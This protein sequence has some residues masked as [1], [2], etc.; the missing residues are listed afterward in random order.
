MK[1]NNPF[2]YRLSQFIS[3]LLGIRVFV[4]FL[5]VLALYVSTFFLFNQEESLRRFVFDYK[6]HGIILCSVLSIAAGG[7]INQFYDLE[8]D[9]IQRPF[10]SRIQ[11]FLKTKYFLYSYLILN[12][13]S[14][15][16]AW[17]L[18]PR[19]FAFFFIYQFIMW[20]YSHKLSKIVFVNNLTFVVLT[21]YPFFGMLVYY[22]H[23]SWPLFWMAAFL[24]VILLIIDSLKDILTIRPDK[25]FGYHTIA[26]DYSLRFSA[27]YI[28]LLLITC[29]IVAG[30]IIL[31]IPHFNLLSLYFA[32]STLVL[33]LALYPMIYFRLNRMFWLMNLLRLWVFIG[34]IFMLLNGIFERF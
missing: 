7:L 15:G 25:I 12:T 8:K 4:L 20:F 34:V 18:S 3:F 2:Y 1:T 33:I 13:I 5:L 23:F 32:L 10:R 11:S 6:V 27:T 24:F 21:L 22:Q 30:I 26:T 29:A 14:L 16:I 9:K 19:I 28:S 31:H 17:A